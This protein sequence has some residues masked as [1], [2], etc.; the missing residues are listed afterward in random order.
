MTE[1]QK[2]AL[3]Q[4]IYG[5]LCKTIDSHNWTYDKDEEKLTVFFKLN[6][7]DIPVRFAITV[8]SGRQLIRLLSYLPFE[9]S[10]DHRFDGAIAACVAS[11][12]LVDGSFDYDIEDGS[13]AY[14]MTASYRASEIG[15]ELIDYMIHCAAVTVDQYN[16]KFLAIDKGYLTLEDFIKSEG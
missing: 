8:D 12:G 1:E 14:R 9:M 13:V 11:Y 7:E 5:L 6:G 4:K 16:D 3:A 15:T 10:E 2:I